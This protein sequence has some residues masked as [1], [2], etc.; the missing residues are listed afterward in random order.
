MKKT[1]L[2]LLA[3]CVLGIWQTTTQADEFQSSWDKMPDRIWLGK[4]YWA[5][6]LQ[7]WCISD[8]KAECVKA[9]KN[10]K[11]DL[12]TCQLTS[13]KKKFTMTVRL[14]QLGN[15]DPN[16][17]A[18][19][20][21]GSKGLINEYRHNAIWGKGLNA[22]VRGNGKLF[23]GKETAEDN[24]KQALS[25]IAL[26][27][28]AEP[29]G[30]FYKLILSAH[31]GKTGK[32]LSHLE[33]NDISNEQLIGNVAIV[34]NSAGRSRFWFSN[35][36]VSGPKVSVN[37][38]QAFG[39]ILFAQYTLSNNIMKMTAQMPPIGQKDSQTVNLQIKKAGKW[40]T[41]AEEK[42]DKLARTATFRI[43]NWNSSTAQPYRLVY[44]LKQ[45]DGKV[46]EHYYTGT[47][48]KEP[49]N[50]DT[51]TV[52][53]FTGNKDYGFP[54]A[55]I[56]KNVGIH[57]PDVLFF[58]GDQI[59]EGVARYG[60]QRRPLDKACLDY[61][62]KWYLLGWSFGDLMRDRPTVTIPDDHDVYHPNVFGAGGRKAKHFIDG[63]YTM[64]PEWVNMVQR[65]QSSHLPD[66][67]NPSPI[68]Q[69][70]SVYYTNMNYG[71][72]SFAIIEDRKFKSTP[73]GLV[74]PTGTRADWVK[75]PSFDPKTA[76]VP[77]AVLLGE[78][79]LKFLNAWAG[80]WR[81]VDMKVVLS[82]TVF[83]N[84]ANYHGGEKT[85]LVADYD[86]NGWPQTGRK[87][88]LQ[89]I[90]KGFGFMLSG[91][92]HLASIFHHG[93]DDWCDAGFSM[94]VP[95]IAA[96]Y[97]R[98]WLPEK[99]GKNYQQGMPDYTGGYKDGFGN[100]ITVW[101]VANPTELISSNKTTPGDIK[102][103]QDKA[104][105]YGLVRFNKKAGKVTIECWP[106]LADLSKSK[107]KGQ[108]PGWPMTIDMQDNYGKKP[109]AYL[110]TI[111]VKGMEN[112]VVQI[113]DETNDE[114]VYT[115][116]IRGT[117]FRPKVFRSGN[118]TIK[119]GRQ[120]TEKM[121]TIKGVES[122]P[123]DKKKTIQVDL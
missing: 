122:L 63:G 36:T 104:S 84:M 13:Q 22:G 105:G 77:G 83:A 59:Y 108:F 5:G 93:I 106:I 15:K 97:P 73:K 114:I 25:D 88:A 123:A 47:I 67:Y 38:K 80:D 103:L 23:I 19:F 76:D 115:L 74:P 120:G 27:L 2:C 10:R 121:K 33:K 62:R 92:Q 102:L 70:I 111:E 87:K 7:D 14:G 65:T 101:A 79:Q 95:S 37:E 24:I 94:C 12:L 64:P 66:P 110:P 50:K 69:G 42:I 91:D 90:R 53:G 52:A 116:R 78:R 60:T 46:K 34:C 112:P 31:D 82:Q 57:D 1:Q 71:R 100:L 11:V 45:S 21:V 28:T 96:G 55:N 99:Q 6:P 41:I 107:T 54:N 61:L 29:A 49:V 32:K 51:I 39:P 113:I 8:G 109:L 58:S 48:R 56:V 40:K 117:S 98:A 3:I 30:K 35:W 26:R 72:I 16:S 20:S 9:A 4:E 44:S 68:Q 119:L 81:S 86:S 75:D 17:W 43:T 89:A 18:G 85:F 118:Y